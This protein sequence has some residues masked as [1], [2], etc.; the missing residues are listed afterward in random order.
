[1]GE[2]KKTSNGREEGTQHAPP[3]RVYVCRQLVT[4][5]RFNNDS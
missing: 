5:K 1:M 2:K 4:D 3:V